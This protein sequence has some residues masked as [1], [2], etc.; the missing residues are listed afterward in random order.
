MSVAGS[1][2]V[3]RASWARAGWVVAALV[4]VLAGA[5]AWSASARAEDCSVP[6]LG[7]NAA[8]GPEYESPGWGDAAGWADP[9]QY[10]TIQLADITGNGQDELLAR[11]NDGLE[12][13][14]FDTTLGQWR[15]AIGADGRPEVLTDF[16]SPLP[17]E[18]PDSHG[19]D[20]MVYSTIRAVQVLGNGTESIVA[21]FPDGTHTYD[22]VAPAGTKNIDGGKWLEE[23]VSGP[24]GNLPPS[25]YLNMRV[26]PVQP[27]VTPATLVFQD[28]FY[29]H[30][31]PGTPGGGSW[32]P[33]GQITRTPETT[34]PQYYL[35]NRAALWPILGSDGPHLTPVDVYR[36][37]DGVG[38]QIYDPRLTTYCSFY[39][40]FNDCPQIP[41]TRPYHEPWTGVPGYFG[42]PAAPFS[43]HSS[44]SFGADPSY[45]ET[46]R[47]AN[48]LRGP[49]DNDGY[50]LGRLPDG[51]HVYASSNGADW[52]TSLP[53][54]AA[55]KDPAPPG[56]W[57]SI[58]TG[59]ITGDG[60]T[61]VL[62]L[63]GGQLRAWE[64]KPNGSGGWA[65]SEL[66]A[67]VPLNLGQ[68]FE[69][70]ASYYST[71]QVGPVAGSG[72]P[73]GVIARG[74]FGIR[75]WFYCT[76]GASKVPGC[77]SLQGKTGWTSWLPQPSP[78]VTTAPDASYPQFTG[79][80]AAAWTALNNLAKSKQL[81]D[82][83]ESTVRDVWTATNPVS[84]HDLS[85]LSDGIVLAAGC[86]SASETSVNP[87]AYRV[88]T[89]QPAQS[90][91]TPPTGSSGFTAADW[92]TVVNETLADI[93][94]AQQVN[95]YYT[96]LGNLRRDSFLAEGATL[97]A[98]ADS[99]S[100]LDGAADNS[101][102]L[103][104]QTLL[105]G[106]IG[107][108]GS[109]AG[110]LVADNPIVAAGLGIASYIIGMIPSATPDLTGSQFTGTL[111]DLQNRFAQAVTGEDNAQEEQNYE[112]R[113][114]WGLLRLV[115]QLTAPNGAWHTIDY[116]GLKG[117]MEEGYAVYA[118]KQLLPTMYY[119]YVVTNCS[120]HD[121]DYFRVVCDGTQFTRFAG[122]VGRLPNFTTLQQPT[123][124]DQ[125][126]TP[127][128]PCA[129]YEGAYS[130]Y[131]NS[132][133]P[134]NLGTQ[135][136][137]ASTC[138]YTGL[139]ASAWKYDCTLGVN[140]SLSVGVDGSENGWNFATCVGN[141]VVVG[142]S[143]GTGGSCSGP[144]NGPG[145]ASVGPDGTLQLSITSALPRGFQVRS[146]TLPA[147]RVL[148]EPN[149]PG[150]LLSKSAKGLTSEGSGHGLGAIQLTIAKGG[151]PGG[152]GETLLG[153]TR[154]GPAAS[155]TLQNH[156]N[157]LAATR[158]TTM[159][160]RL[161]DVQVA[162]PEA[163]QQVPASVSMTSPEFM[164]NTSLK[165]S[166]GRSTRTV[167]VP[168]LWSCDYNN[169]GSVTELRT[170]AP[171]VP[172]ERPG[173]AVSI[174]GPQRVTPGSQVTYTVRLLNTRRGRGSR[175][176][177]SLWNVEAQTAL[178]PFKRNV[179]PGPVIRRL[180]E[181]PRGKS[182]TLRIPIHI[183]ATA[184][185]VKRLCVSVL[186][187]ADSAR[188]A[189]AQACAAIRAPRK[190]KR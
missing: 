37:A 145:L 166:N 132:P 29:L 179:T 11:N 117:A 71:I 85:T 102:Q 57:S 45:Y 152:S 130:C 69:G 155:L 127:Q 180:R 100:A 128:R 55:L 185:K 50:V 149:G 154:S 105:S 159:R 181:L 72:Y 136:W 101:V 1:G 30:S 9:S 134:N 118:Y 144:P 67:A 21:Q 160:L 129:W 58:R 25:D 44:P 174:S 7:Y 17:T 158:T 53:V 122:T 140:P 73:D 111:G 40:S 43:D 65:W 183:P 168:I 48:H 6:D 41:T 79:A 186:A 156:A 94:Y 139:P 36:T 10:S 150:N 88:D 92:T 82:T 126:G 95:D 38:W 172:T 123:Y 189:R 35:D 33:S 59:D 178:N 62:G 2:V 18:S 121:A 112:V 86:S 74:P 107:I 125:G 163:C 133:P 142:T 131:Y 34:D 80:Q 162:V 83:D 87:P 13:W 68:T 176:I 56:E 106:A 42:G 115:G 15:P 167:S 77:A 110:V 171:Q 165:L 141:P 157:G 190:G 81:I 108:G 26:I 114:N 90:G 148:Y 47:V 103:S 14:T 169:R 135:V 31:G 124:V 76:G 96:N 16:R 39:G 84:D 52:D 99:I 113:Q 116:I 147:N 61:D 4:V 3:G 188:P 175:E 64:L 146:A 32:D 28:A 151:Q 19:A 109:I 93:Y 89:A 184:G 54:L 97:P 24:T 98:I 70:N 20:P 137:G 75:T 12:I 119:R 153:G 177:S 46:L 91:C 120:D 66:P 187:T 51:L 23:P 170:V 8:C 143:V 49:G 22:Y 27:Y 161:S 78:Q 164:L 5:L 173:L 104:A 60:R 138:N 182:N 63:V